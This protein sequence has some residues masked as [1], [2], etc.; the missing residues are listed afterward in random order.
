MDLS[1]ADGHFLEAPL[2]WETL[3]RL[4]AQILQVYQR[5]GKVLLAGVGST[6]E[7]VQQIAQEL[8]QVCYLEGDRQG[9]FARAIQL[10]PLPPKGD[11]HMHPVE[12]WGEPGDLFLGFSVSGRSP[13]LLHAF[14]H[15]QRMGI[16]A[17]GITGKNGGLL[18]PHC[19]LCLQ[20]PTV[21]TPRILDTYEM[22]GGILRVDLEKKLHI[23]FN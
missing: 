7:R 5:N 21:D 3:A 10:D 18:A 17:I 20:V 11:K 12:K 22:I 13:S 8:T 15:C 16:I 23:S 14:Q 2:F 19:G 1:F 9:L 6:T 4:S